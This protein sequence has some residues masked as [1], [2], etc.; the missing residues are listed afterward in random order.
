MASRRLHSRASAS[1][2]STAMSM[3][4]SVTKWASNVVVALSE[5]RGLI[6]S[7][8]TASE[9]GLVCFDKAAGELSLSQYADTQQYSKVRVS[10]GLDCRNFEDDFGADLIV[11]VNRAWFNQNKG[12]QNI[13]EFSLEE[14]VIPGLSSKLYFATSCVAAILTYVEERD[15]ITYYRNS[16]RFKFFSLDGIMSIDHITARNL[17]LIIN[18]ETNKSAGSLFGVLNN[19]QTGMGARL[20]R[21][22]VLQPLN[23]LETINCR[24][25]AVEDL[26]S[27]QAVL[28]DIRMVLKASVDMDALIMTLLYRPKKH[29]VKVTENYITAIITLKH[30]ISNW[31]SAIH[32]II[33]DCESDLLKITCSNLKN[34]SI[35]QL[36]A[37]IDE[38][39]NEDITYQK[40]AQG[41]RNQRCYAVK[42]GWNGLLDVARQTYRES[43][44]DVYDLVAGYS[45]TYGLPIKTNYSKSQGFTLKLNL[46]DLDQGPGSMPSEFI[47][48]VKTKK[49]ATF[50]TLALLGFNDRI[51]ESLT[52][53]YLMSDKIIAELVVDVSRFAGLLYNISESIALLDML[54]SFAHVADT[55]D[56]VRPEF[57][58]TLA[59]KAGRHP[60]RDHFA[61]NS[62]DK[63]V[64][65]DVY[66]CDGANMQ[67][68]SGP[69]MS[70]KTTYLKMIVLL[71]IV[72]Q[73]GSF[74]PA[75]YA[76]FR[77]QA[78]VFSRIGCDSVV[79]ASVSSFMSEMRESAYIL[80]NV[81]DRSL[82]I[83]DELGRGTS[84]T[85]G[86]AMS[87]AISEKLAE[88]KAFTFI[89]THFIELGV[90]LASTY[91]NVVKLHLHVEC[92]ERDENV[93]IHF[94]YQVQD[95]TS[96]VSNYGLTI[97]KL[98][99]FPQSTID[100]ALQVANAL[101]CAANKKRE[102]ALTDQE[103][104]RKQ[105]AIRVY[106]KLVQARL[107]SR[108]NEP[109]LRLYLKSLKEEL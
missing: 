24:L 98:A 89:A 70:G 20:L 95:G 9:V 104:I 58:E 38:R 87:I 16:L 71:N 1:R 102:E 12:L 37:L 19:C 79:E 62:G 36:A 74:I 59:V 68:I 10:N 25:N 100:D 41:M 49:Q 92:L 91:A 78:Q 103:R 73:M 97:A 22:N 11:P 80:Q 99:H 42:A 93:N 46:A 101:D 51:N 26:K 82:V 33:T 47:N 66:C 90:N 7:V 31:I 76:S 40:N 77:L 18:L 4:T 107:N 106:Y 2:P 56:F 6:S 50:T 81:C 84:H 105:A 63:F 52:E 83:I 43:T 14:S 27:N 86:I 39:I 94:K 23:D 5:G 48:V 54:A 30:L 61:S 34:E 8:G 75:E 44:N 72:A 28:S 13:S 32:E 21:M 53:V 69:N 108:L 64:P 15:E 65:N 67:I 45:T 29:T 85:D 55:S 57:T 88:T 109:A 60:I 35:D 96:N 17:E 3:A